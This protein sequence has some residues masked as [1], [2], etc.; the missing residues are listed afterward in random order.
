M[1]QWTDI[2]RRVLVA[3]VSKRQITRETGI[4]FKTL[5]KILTHSSPP[6]YRRKKPIQKP[7][8]GPY[9]DRISQII[10]SDKQ[11]RR[12]QRHTAKRIWEILQAEGFRGGYTI[13]KDAVRELKALSKEVFV[14]LIHRP[15]EAQVDFGEAAVNMA[16]QL[17]KVVFFVMSLLHSDG[18]F[19]M[20]FDRECTETFWEGHVRAFDFFGFVPNTTRYDNARVQVAGIIGSR[21]RKL[22]Q[23]FQQLVS[24]YLFEP[25]FCLV[26]RA[27]EKGVVEGSVKYARLNFFV[28]VPQ[29]KD[30]TE[31]NAYL[32]EC[33]GSDLKRRLRGKKLTKKELLE[34]DKVAS[35]PLPG[36]R[37]DAYRKRSTF[38]NSQSLIRFDNNDYSVPVDYAHQPVIIKANFEKVRLCHMNNLIAEHQR[39]WDKEQ[40]IFNPLHYLRLIQRKPG[41]LDH[42]RPLADLKL[43]ECFDTLRRILESRQDDG[44]REYIRVLRLLEN[45]SI[46][47]VSRA[48]DKALELGVYCRD[49]IAQFL[50]PH[51]PWEHTTFRLDGREHLRHVKVSDNDVSVYRE[52][53]AGGV[54]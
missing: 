34:E 31:L 3:G 30:F 5:Q 43:P 7:K 12:N 41:S 8:I 15:G 22:T 28:P 52:L 20:A 23:G 38:A 47:D 14:P 49:A 36:T 44:I 2:R 37:F 6:G 9:L 4:H 16:G 42:S 26:R 29:V 32:L 13:V 46:C 25:T 45:H 18:F 24:H 21:R 54:A 40:Q 1:E 10:E 50:I 11:Q 17:R 51:E 53:L 48:I 35:L 27:N 19:V 39:C 33:C